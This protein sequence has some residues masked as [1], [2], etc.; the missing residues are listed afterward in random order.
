[1]HFIVTALP[2]L[3]TILLT[4]IDASLARP[5]LEER[6]DQLDFLLYKSSDC[7]GGVQFASQAVGEQTR[8]AFGDF[9]SV[10]FSR[11]PVA[12]E[13]VQF[14]RPSTSADNKFTVDKNSAS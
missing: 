2:L 10:K 13:S 8:P 3:L 6:R 12:G 11:V 5:T 4:N 14:L 1:M 7:T 9:V